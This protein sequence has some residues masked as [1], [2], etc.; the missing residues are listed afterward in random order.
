MEKPK[1]T[2]NSS[3]LHLALGVLPCVI[4]VKI[5]LKFSKLLGLTQHQ[6]H[7]L[8]VLSDYKHM[9]FSVYSI[10]EMCKND[11]SIHDF[12]DFELT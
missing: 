7:V 11:N 2:K 8:K 5:V 4:K 12:P 1:I 10:R 3:G 9:L 6:K